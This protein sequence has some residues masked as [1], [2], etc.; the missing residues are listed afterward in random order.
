MVQRTLRYT[1]DNERPCFNK[2]NEKKLNKQIVKIVSIGKRVNE[3]L[4][5][6]RSAITIDIDLLDGM[7]IP[8]IEFN[9]TWLDQ[10][11]TKGA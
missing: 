5:H 6:T 1:T 4:E 10:L 9:L 2:A 11:S 7:E 8:N 3:I